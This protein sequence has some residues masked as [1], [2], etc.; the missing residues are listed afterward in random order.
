VRRFAPALILILWAAPLPAQQTGVVEGRVTDVESG[1]PVA[2]A[3][4]RVVGTV[5]RTFADDSGR[6]VLRGVPTGEQRLRAE[7]IG[8]VPGATTVQVPADGRVEVEIVMSPEPVAL[9]EIITVATRRTTTTL[10]APISVSVMEEPE[11]MLRVPETVADAVAY[12]PAAQFVGEQLNIRGLSGYARGTGSRVLLLIDGVPANA[13]DSGA[14]NWDVIP[15]TEVERLEV[16]KGPNSALYGTGALGGVVNIVTARAPEKPLTRLR[17]VGGLYDNPPQEDWTWSNETQGF[18]SGE[19]SHGRRVGDFGFWLRGG[20]WFDDGYRQ[21]GDLERTN[22]A[23][24]VEW[25]G[26]SDTVSVFG[27][28]AREDYGAALLWCMRGECRD[29]YQLAFQPLKI[30]LD[31][32]DDRTR[33]D[34][35]RAFLGHRHNWSETLNS[36]F[37]LSYQ[38][39][40]WETDFGNDTVGSVSNVYGG[41]LQFDWRAANWIYLITGGEGTYTPVEAN[42]FGKH[43]QSIASGYIQGEFELGRWVTL[44]A[45]ARYDQ[46]WMD[47][48]NYS[49]QVSPR[50]GVVLAPYPVT[51]IRASVGRGFR[52]PTVAEMFTATE[53]GGFLVIPN[54]SLLPERSWAAELGI[55]Q[56]A[57]SWLS[58]DVA[59]FFYDLADFIEADTT[60]TS[61]GGIVIQFDNLPKARIAGVEAIAVMSFLRD[62]LRGQVAYT[63]LLTEDRV[64]GE[65]LAYRP[66]HHLLTA[67]GTF[68]FRGLEFGADYRYASPYDH[69]KVFTSPVTDP[70]VAM[71]VLDLRI[72]Y[73]FGR[74]VIRF[75]VDNSANYAYTTIERNME[76]VRRYTLGLDIQF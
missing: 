47:G 61:E 65:P 5:L 26:A 59:G 70:I 36:F 13:G 44:T 76:P 35:T 24:E 45:G 8:Y 9:G 19:L 67:S 30:P 16:L 43:D 56:L 57:A 42:L 69:V 33:S 10:D 15:L 34:K 48:G 68:T 32:R 12:V 11:I 73:R 53:V 14:I 64:T 22:L 50:A 3:L 17:L 4:V 7:R 29:P 27:S 58:F 31:A 20:Q 38:R 25:A 2:T 21:R 62:R 51:R 23:G 72:A 75:M 71:S 55:Q 54:D 18:L 74:Q 6:F 28:W 60:A 63:Y 66:Q 46:V 37:R 49:S 40:D 41:E 39:N 1:V 52:A